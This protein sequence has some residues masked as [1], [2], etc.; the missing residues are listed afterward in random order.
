MG[1]PFSPADCR[2]VQ[3]QAERHPCEG[4]G[5]YNGHRGRDCERLP[6]ALEYRNIYQRV[7]SLTHEKAVR[8]RFDYESA[9]ICGESGAPGLTR[10]RD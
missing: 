10:A 2:T 6:N 9:L 5:G 3:Q 7:G 4:E 8:A 1:D